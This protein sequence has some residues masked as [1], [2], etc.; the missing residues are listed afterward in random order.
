MVHF[1]FEYALGS[2]YNISIRSHSGA[3]G[4]GGLSWITADT[5]IGEPDPMPLSPTVLTNNGRTTTIEI[6]Q[7]V[8][9]NGPI[10]AIQV[11]VV[12][13]DAEL[14]QQF[15]E[16]LLKSHSQATEDGTNYYITAELP[17]EVFFWSQV[18][19]CTKHNSFKMQ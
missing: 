16:N 10:T 2:M 8:N 14:S 19:A 15:D 3:Y 18:C 17:Y 9:N 6:P 4:A 1:A 12:F 5:E 13:L 7:L 11:V